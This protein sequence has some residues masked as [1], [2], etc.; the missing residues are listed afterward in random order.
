MELGLVRALLHQPQWIFV[1]EALDSLLPD[2]EAKMLKLLAHKLS[3]AGILTISHQPSIF[4]TRSQSLLDPYAATFG[5]DFMLPDNCH[6]PSKTIDRNRI[7]TV[8]V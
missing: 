7:F 2:D 5:Y 6:S 3:H 4:L 1:Q 8:S